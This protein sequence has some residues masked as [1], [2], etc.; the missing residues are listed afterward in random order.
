MART[1]TKAEKAPTTVTPTKKSKRIQDV[2]T[3]KQCK[4]EI[5]EWNSPL[6]PCYVCSTMDYCKDCCDRV[7]NLRSAKL[8]FFSVFLFR[9]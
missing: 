8:T 1:K 5:K 4:E 7:C 6:A 9:L 2:K 3:C